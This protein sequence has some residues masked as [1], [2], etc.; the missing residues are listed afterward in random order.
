MSKSQDKNG[1]KVKSEESETTDR[2]GVEDRGFEK[3]GWFRRAVG[4]EE[5]HAEDCSGIGET[6]WYRGS[7]LR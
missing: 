7:G 3:A 2:R 5:G 6:G 4:F 1:Q